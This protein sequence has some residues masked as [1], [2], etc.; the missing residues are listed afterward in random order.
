MFGH[1]ATAITKHK[2]EKVKKEDMVY[3]ICRQSNTDR[4]MICCD[5]CDEWFHGDCIGITKDEAQ[6]IRHF[7]CKTCLEANPDLSIKY[8]KKKVKKEVIEKAP[9]DDVI[10]DVVV[11]KKKHHSEKLKVLHIITQTSHEIVGTSGKLV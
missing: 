5:K 8:K 10:V 3:C 7:Y 1:G 6:T 11:E 4:F 9:E 2:E